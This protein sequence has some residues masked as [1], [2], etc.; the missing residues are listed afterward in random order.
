MAQAGRAFEGLEALLGGSGFELQ[1]NIWR[2]QVG[3]L[4]RQG[5]SAV[6]VAAV[7]VAAGIKRL[8]CMGYACVSGHPLADWSVDKSNCL[9][10]YAC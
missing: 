6:D 3:V 7:D 5:L 10:L 8:I 2:R 1:G 9:L 4:K